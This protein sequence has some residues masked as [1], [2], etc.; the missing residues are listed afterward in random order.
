MCLIAF[1]WQPTPQLKLLMAANRDE[2][3]GRPS[4][5]LKPWADDPELLA[6]RDATA[7]GTWLGVSTR[8][9]IAAVTNVRLPTMEA[10]G[11]RSRGAL[12]VAF[13][14]G[15]ESPGAHRDRLLPALADYGPCNLLIAD[16]Q[17]ACY[18]SNRPGIAPQTLQPGVYGLSNAA[19]DTPWPKTVALKA[20][21]QRWL[22]AG[23]L[24]DTEAL[25][26]ALANAESPPDAALPDTGVGLARERF[27]APAFIRGREY[28]TR[29]STLVWV[30]A[31][32][33]GRII[34]RRFG[35]EGVL[36]GET[37]LGFDWPSVIDRHRA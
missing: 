36:L 20:A 7:M 17:E 4:L 23:A 5:P 35:P 21:V 18:L 30:T 8:G 31:S 26:T 9:R 24:G 34:E 33:E 32:G 2:F 16:A 29:C 10:A 19:L 28:G 14:Q 1:A 6:G 27:V 13:L 3:H 22:D 11:L 15:S 25:F 12:P 37:Q